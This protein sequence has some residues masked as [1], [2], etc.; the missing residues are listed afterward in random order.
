[1][2]KLKTV[3]RY[4]CVTSFKYIWCFYAIEYL[5][6][7][8]ISLIIA[9]STGSME[10][11]GTNCLEVNSLIFS[12]ILGVLGFKEDFKMLIQNGFTRKYI[13]LATA[14]L[15]VFIAGIMS[16]VDAVTGNVLHHI[17]NDYS[18][19]Y[20]GLYG[21]DSILSNWIWLFLVYMVICV[22]MYLGILVINKIGKNLS[23]LVGILIGGLILIGIAIVRFVLP[24]EVVYDLLNALQ[25]AFGFMENGTINYLYPSLT[26]LLIV[27]ILGLGSYA[28]IRRT[29]LV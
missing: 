14:A 26:L 11:V 9:I 17:L 18:S 15:F 3:I 24:E 19:L 23:L 27:G 7:T 6:I 25:R 2:R 29:E 20:G 13:F 5:I 21:Y 8:F 22:L 10:N 1:M 12:G 16:F 28:V 4:E